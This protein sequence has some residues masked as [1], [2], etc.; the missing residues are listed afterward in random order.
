MKTITPTISQ[1]RML[2]S[3]KGQR[4]AIRPEA[5]EEFA[6]SALD[7]AENS[8]VMDDPDFQNQRAPMFMDA[9]GIA[10]IEITGA[11]LNKVAQI[12]ERNGL[13]TAYSTIIRETQAAKDAG[14]I[15]IIYHVDSPGG[16]VA[17]VVEAGAAIANAGIPTAA[18]CHGLSCSAAYWLTSGTNAIIATPSAT[19][20]NIGA[21]LSWA[22]CSAFWEGMGVKFKALVSEGADLKSTFH[23][24]PDEA[25]LAFLQES[26]NDAGAAFREHVTTGRAAA[27]VTMDD[28]VWRAG[29]YSGKR[30]GQ[31]GLVDDI[32]GMETAR[33]RI[34][35]VAKNFPLAI[36]QASMKSRP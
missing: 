34:L 30:A 35:E 17:G 32:G 13:A 31:L 12:Y 29:W 21:I 9:D 26:I 24:E 18:F 33:E 15:G 16:T 22:D 28:E 23:L 19:V 11:L 7:L 36:R 10:H 4:W 25:Q 1:L 6:L 14:A 5:V 2:S 20:G 8:A 3:I 27:G